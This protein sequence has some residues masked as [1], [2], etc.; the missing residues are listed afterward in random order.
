LKALSSNLIK[1][2]FVAAVGIPALIFISYR[3]G[4]WLYIFCVL[5]AVL[6]SWELSAM[7]MA[8]NVRVGKRLATFLAVVLVSMFQF[9]GFGQQGLLAIFILFMLA[10]TLK[11]VETGI[12]N[13][14]S[15]LSMA[16]L[17]AIYPGF[18]VSFSI[19]IHREFAPLGWV[20]LVFTFVNTWLADTFAYAFGRLL[21]KRKLAPTIS[22]GKTWVG[23]IASF[24]GGLIAPFVA[25]P[26][27]PGWAIGDLMLI[28]VVAT[29]FGQIGDLIESAIKR[30]C[31]VKDSSSLIPGHGGVLDRFDSFLVALPAVYFL[32][33]FLV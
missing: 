24:P 26:F 28:S 29:A 14:T 32:L 16:V 27:L 6:G 20:F 15:R 21:G 13:Y 5:V 10:A 2:L 11:L 23:L 1:R 4:Y 22:P 3:G 30:D 12:V 33:R 31:G 7:L 25:Q 9:S 19:L 17:A 18:F 8:K